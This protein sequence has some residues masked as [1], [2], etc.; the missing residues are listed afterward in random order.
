M[1]SFDF[2]HEVLPYGSVFV[3]L[4]FGGLVFY[5][6]LLSKR[7]GGAILGCGLLGGA[8]LVGVLRASHR[9]P[10]FVPC[11]DC[12]ALGQ[13]WYSDTVTFLQGCGIGSAVA[14]SLWWVNRRKSNPVRQA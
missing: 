4:V 14:F 9:L 12:G 10:W 8:L 2:Q 1:S 7:A 3:P 6:R 13:W 5:R 11:L